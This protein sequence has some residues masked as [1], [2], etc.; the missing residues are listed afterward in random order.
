MYFRMLLSCFITF[1]TMYLN[2]DV[3]HKDFDILSGDIL[4]G[5]I[6]SGDILSGDIFF[7]YGTFCFVTF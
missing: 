4:S 5:D 6:L 2:F 1:H 7:K 3:F